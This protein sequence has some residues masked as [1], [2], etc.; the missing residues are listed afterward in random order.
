[1]ETTQQLLETNEAAWF[2]R[3]S[4]AAQ[5]EYERK[6]P[7]QRDSHAENYV[8]P[9]HGKDDRRVGMYRTNKDG[10]K[11][12]AFVAIRKD[13]HTG[14]ETRKTYGHTE[15]PNK[16]YYQRNKAHPD[17]GHLTHEVT[18]FK[19][20]DNRNHILSHH[21][22][23]A[24]GDGSKENHHKVLTAMNSYS[25]HHDWKLHE[26]DK[27]SGDGSKT[28][29]NEDISI[30]NH[31]QINHSKSKTDGYGNLKNDTEV[32]HQDTGES[33]TLKKGTRVFF[34]NDGQHTH[35]THYAGTGSN[36]GQHS[37]TFKNTDHT[38]VVE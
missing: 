21:L 24:Y 12:H 38:Q 30:I 5:E 9:L 35:I 10:T 37:A 34:H 11:E 3:L 25:K 1:M 17:L 32:H 26:D 6:H 19:S 15:T 8:N 33:S 27:P 16:P 29:L 7:H 36:N 20:K 13:P 28:K 2:Q 31:E 23:T 4:P 18:D 22:H 14:Q